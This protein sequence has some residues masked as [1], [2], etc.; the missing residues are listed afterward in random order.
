MKS[1]SI[2]VF[3]IMVSLILANCSDDNDIYEYETSEVEPQED[4]PSTSEND[5]LDIF[6]GFPEAIEEYQDGDLV[7]REYYY[8][9]ADGNLHKV[10]YD[11]IHGYEIIYGYDSETKDIYNYD[12]EGKLINFRSFD[13]LNIN[14]HWDNGHIAEADVDTP[15][16]FGYGRA[17][18]YY[19][20][21]NKNRI[22]ESITHYQ[23]G[24]DLKTIYTY[25]EDGNVK[26]IEYYR[27]IEIGMNFEPFYSTT[28]D[29]Y[30]EDQNLF[31][32]VTI[33][34]GQSIQQRFPTSVTT[35]HYDGSGPD[36]YESYEYEYD[37]AGRVI[38]RISG[39]NK[40]VYLYR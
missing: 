27:N 24:Q 3:L 28:Y 13:D 7:H 9:N 38:A 8:Y 10:K 40:V 39:S 15:G 6:S 22:T 16:T 26:S 36:T 18:I 21:D 11:I 4:E 17:K 29:G 35:K 1:G 37:A 31:F 2:L 25:Y 23:N 33:I 5:D 12:N 19:T 14:F 34:P 30:T 20:Y 32:E